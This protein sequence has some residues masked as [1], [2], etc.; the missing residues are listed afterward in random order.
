MS[1]NP[2]F[3][4]CKNNLECYNSISIGWFGINND[5]DPTQ[6]NPDSKV[7]NFMCFSYRDW[8]CRLRCPGSAAPSRSAPSPGASAPCGRRLRRRGPCSAVLWGRRGCHGPCGGYR[9]CCGGSLPISSCGRWHRPRDCSCSSSPPPHRPWSGG[10]PC[11][12]VPSLAERPQS[13]GRSTARS[14]G[15]PEETGERKESISIS[16][17]RR[18]ETK[19]YRNMV[20]HCMLNKDAPNS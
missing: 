11:R 12:L 8:V 20:I 5:R 19:L 18:D 4:R 17:P 7:F 1:S 9:G 15:K 3:T 13:A 6:T 14:S 16:T 10:T 2:K